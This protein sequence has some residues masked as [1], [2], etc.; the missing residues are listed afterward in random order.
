LVFGD[1]NSCLPAIIAKRLRIPVFHMEAGNRSFDENVPEEINRRIIDHIADFNLVSTEH[2]RHHLISEGLP[3]RRIYLT[4]SPMK[5]VIDHYL[6]K[7]D[8]SQILQELQ[9]DIKRYFLVSMHREENVDNKVNLIKMTA[10]LERLQQEYGLPVI[11]STHPRTRRD[12]RPQR[13]W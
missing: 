12:W 2:A 1:S 9:L 11:V 4:G 3:H 5:E 7:I 8:N 6:P 10:L 13:I